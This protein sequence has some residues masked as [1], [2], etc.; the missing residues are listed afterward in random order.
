MGAFSVICGSLTLPVQSTCVG[1]QASSCSLAA[2]PARVLGSHDD[3]QVLDHPESHQPSL[4]PMMPSL[5]SAAVGTSSAALSRKQAAP[6]SR[7]CQ[8]SEKGQQKDSE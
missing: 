8:A 1:R 5:S 7:T 3:V 6:C 4:W 2:F